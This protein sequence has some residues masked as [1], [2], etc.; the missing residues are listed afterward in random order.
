VKDD[1]PAGC[2]VLLLAGQPADTGA[3]IVHAEL[4]HRPVV[5]NV[6][7]ATM[8]APRVRFAAPLV[9]A[10]AGL[11]AGSYPALRAASLEPVEALR[12]G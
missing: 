5:D 4:A 2:P 3:A 1:R 12:S 6:L 10:V 7:Q 11:L 9:G 8:L